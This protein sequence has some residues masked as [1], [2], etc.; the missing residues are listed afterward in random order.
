M[1]NIEKQAGELQEKLI[2]VNRVS[3][4][5]KGGRIFSFAA[6]T[7]VGDGNGR[8]GFGYGKAREVPAAIQKAMEKAR[9][10]MVNVAITEGTLQHPV[11][12]THTG[13]R[14]FM[15]PASEGTGII[16]GGA[17]RAVLEVAGVRNVLSKA[18]GSTNPINVVRATIDALANMKSPEMV[19]AKRG[20]TVDEILG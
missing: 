4:T 14:V 6:L 12:G 5:V 9:R 3:K 16:A 13:S 15:Q 10:N 7:V 20:K 18:Y 2:A 1:A 8:V 11:K 19:A 17:M